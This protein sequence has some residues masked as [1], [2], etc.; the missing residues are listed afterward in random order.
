MQESKFARDK[1]GGVTHDEMILDRFGHIVRL[2]D[3]RLEGENLAGFH[4]E[5]AGTCDYLG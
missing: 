4:R 2:R 3:G 5:I 1:S